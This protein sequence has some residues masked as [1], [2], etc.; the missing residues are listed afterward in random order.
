MIKLER[1]HERIVK[2]IY[3][4]RPEDRKSVENFTNE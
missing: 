2:W 3:I 4:V 1:S